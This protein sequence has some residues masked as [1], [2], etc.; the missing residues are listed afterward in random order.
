MSNS[1]L[2]L[3]AILAGFLLWLA[4]NDRLKVYAAMLFG[5]GSGS[6]APAPAAPSYLIPPVPWLGFPGVTK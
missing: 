4:M 3:G 6:A 2:A 5:G 1:Q